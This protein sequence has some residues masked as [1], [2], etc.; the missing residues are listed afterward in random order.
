MRNLKI[1]VASADW[2][3]AVDALARKS[4]FTRDFANPPMSL[5]LM[6]RCAFTDKEVMVATHNDNLLGFIWCRAMLPKH[7]PFSTVYYMGVDPNA[8]HKGV[9]RAM[10]LAAL[11]QAKCGRIELV[12]EDRNEAAMNFYRN[13]PMEVLREGAVGKDQRPYTRWYV[14]APRAAN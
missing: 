13:F 5:K 9:A 3:L 10:L 11:G 12:C 1:E 7:M 6:R 4:L 14:E 2:E 8:V